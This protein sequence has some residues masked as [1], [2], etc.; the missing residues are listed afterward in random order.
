VQRI[1]VFVLVAGM[2]AAGCRTDD[3]ASSEVTMPADST[4]PTRPERPNVEGIT[5]TGPIVGVSQNAARQDLT[6][7]GYVEEE[8]FVS[9]S[10]D[11][12]AAAGDLGEDGRWEVEPGDTA[13]YTSRLLV[14]RP[15]APDAFSTCSTVSAISGC[16]A[17]SATVRSTTASA[18]SS[19]RPRC[20]IS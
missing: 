3:D 17:A 1:W 14:R 7:A 6:S 8:F 18:T 9:G 16:A 5:V 19:P 13:P 15:A 2:L 11:A 4:R 10:A 12:Y 20:T